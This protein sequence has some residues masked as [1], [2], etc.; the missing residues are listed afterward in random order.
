MSGGRIVTILF[1]D[2][3]G[4]TE[5]TDRLGDEAAETIRRT[6]FAVLREA[7][8]AHGG[9]EVKNL[10]DGIM[11]IF[12]SAVGAV[13]CA[14]E[15]QRAV[16]RHNRRPSTLHRLGVRIGLHLGEPIRDEDDYFGGAVN[17][18]KRLCDACE[19][20]QILCSDLVRGLARARSEV[21]FRR[22]DAIELKGISEPVEPYEVVWSASQASEIALPPGI[23]VPRPTPYVGR[24]DEVEMLRTEWKRA[25]AGEQRTVL[26]AGEP[27]IGKTRIATEV[28]KEAHADGAVVLF[29]RCDEET[30]IPYQPFVEALRYYVTHAPSADLTE[31]LG[32]YAADL[33]RLIPDLHDRIP[34]LVEPAQLDPDAE[35]YRLFLAVECLLTAAAER[36]PLFLILDDLHWADRP[37]LALLKQVIRSREQVPFLICGT[38]R[39]VELSRRHPFAEVL[40]DLRREKVYERLLLRGLGRDDVVSFLETIGQQTIDERMRQLA[41]ALHTETEGN[42]FFIEEILLHLVETGRLY[43]DET[44][45][46]VSDVDVSELS[47]PE[48]VR[49]AVGRR[50]ARLSEHANEALAHAS[51]IGPRF[52][53]AVLARMVEI[54]DDELSRA[55][56]AA[57]VTALIVET[58]DESGAIYAFA[59]ALVRQVLYEELSLPRRQRLHLKAGD[60][61][62][63]V[64]TKEPPLG[65][66]ATHYRAAGAAADAQKA[67]DYS[68]FAGQQAAGVYAF[69]EALKHLDAAY[70][71]M[72]DQ[73]ADPQVRARLLGY[74][75]DLRFMTGID[76]AKGIDGLEEALRIYESTGDD[77]HAAQTHS[78]LGRAFSTFGGSTVDIERALQHFRRGKDLIGRN[79]ASSSLGYIHVGL[80]AGALWGMRTAEGLEASVEAVAL[81]EH[82]GNQTLLA[83]ARLLYGWHLWASGRTSEGIT[84]IEET[85]DRLDQLSG[86]TTATFIAAWMRGFIANASGDP[87]TAQ[88]W[89]E[90]ELEHPRTASAPQ[91]AQVLA[92]LAGQAVFYQGGCEEL[93]R[94]AGQGDLTDM[95]IAHIDGDFATVYRSYDDSIARDLRTGNRLQSSGGELG[96]G[97]ALVDEQRFDEALVRFERALA[98]GSEHVVFSSWVHLDTAMVHVFG[99]RHEEARRACVRASE[100]PIDDALSRSPMVLQ[101]RA[102]ALLVD[103]RLEDAERVCFEGIEAARH[104]SFVPMV[105]WGLRISAF[106]HH[107]AGRSDVVDMRFKEVEELYRSHGFGPKLIALIEQQRRTLSRH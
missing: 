58:T 83:N 17:T 78:R 60:A 4:S 93:R 27:G 66:I 76:Y 96:Y 101:T 13:A 107:L 21:E 39:D 74:L 42:P 47:I 1:T 15:M 46:W 70:E 84:I 80:A 82:T 20:G 102:C 59:H 79:D 68:L 14:V 37:T 6:H 29:G 19:G 44:G 18:A 22:L 51:V 86:S 32:E 28:A 103:G 16:E 25:L 69:E 2:L 9:E 3:V 77:E 33:A 89:V 11:V 36:A 43:Q 71:L 26:I 98:G 35:R 41:D 10:G 94:R 105:D 30:V 65:A 99:G 54:T 100:L 40:A 48:G 24:S 90:R 57:L 7:V 23:A 67:I 75:G 64:H 88:T 34:G 53:Y 63:A 55:L 87:V 106:I 61:L 38:Y 72:R 50:L 92:T 85:Y 97:L 62:A 45:R 73:D 81:A 5:L 91:L 12:E 49:E 52:E 95:Y 104:A 8:A 56:E 31:E